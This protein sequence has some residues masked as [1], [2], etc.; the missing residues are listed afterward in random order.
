MILRPAEA[1]TKS[2]GGFLPAWAVI[3][4]AQ[5]RA[6]ADCWV[7]TQPDHAKLSGEIASAISSSE[8]P[9]LDSDVVAGI[10]LRRLDRLRRSRRAGVSGRWLPGEPPFHAHRAKRSGRQQARI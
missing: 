2:G 3:E 10:A 6:A 5:R 9:R 4:N 8:Y 1:A 7:V